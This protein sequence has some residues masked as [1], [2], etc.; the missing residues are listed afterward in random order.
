VRRREF[1]TLLGGAAVSSPL[2]ARAQQPARMRRIGVLYS[3]A[4]A[5]KEAVAHM[6][7]FR[8][9][10]QKAGWADGHNIR[11][12][13]RGALNDESRQRFAKELVA[14]QPD[15]ILSGGTAP[16]VALLRQTRSIPIIFVNSA[17]PV[18]SGLVKSL[19]RPGGNVTGF[20][21]LEP[22]MASKWLELLKGVAPHVAS[23]AFLF[24]PATAPYADN[25]LS[26]FKAAAPSFGVEAITTPVHDASEFETIIAAQARKPNSGL[27]VMPDPF[28]FV[29]RA[30]IISLAMRHRLPVV[31]SNRG[32]TELGGLLSYGADLVENL[33]G[34]AS[35]GDRILRGDKPSE[36]PIQ[37]PVKFE[38]VINL[39]T[40]KALGL[41]VPDKLL[42]AADEVIE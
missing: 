41:T 20:I 5:D 35:Y 38:L 4:E 33:R 39:N 42:A 1:I 15:L 27:I 2:V 9:A 23:I 31:Y 24:N 3:Y 13:Y 22:T 21:N 14:L 19:A 25:Y 36:L 12:D 11:I 8:E 26:P 28:P 7:A 30:E 6:A 17:D 40:A 18:G 29:H 16:T 32:Y 10:L 37:V 34:A